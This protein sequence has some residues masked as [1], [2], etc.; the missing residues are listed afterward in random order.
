MR[1]FVKTEIP[2]KILERRIIQ[3]WKLQFHKFLCHRNL[4]GITM[5][6]ENVKEIG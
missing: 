2:L 6:P 5:Y 4:L 1:A 3:N